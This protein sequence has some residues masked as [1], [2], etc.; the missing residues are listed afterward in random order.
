MHK[1]NLII[2]IY[3]CT[4]WLSLFLYG[5]YVLD[6]YKKRNVEYLLSFFFVGLRLFTYVYYKNKYFLSHFGILLIFL[7][8]Y[9][10]IYLFFLCNK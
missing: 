1:D 9:H 4:Y 2:I 10:K 7:I 5:K 6:A 3:K 8:S